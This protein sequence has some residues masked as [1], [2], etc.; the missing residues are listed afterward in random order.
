MRTVLHLAVVSF[1]ACLVACENDGKSN[2]DQDGDGI[3]D[4]F[5]CNDGDPDIG[6]TVSY[7]LDADKDGY[8][9]I[10]GQIDIG[11]C[12]PPEGFVLVGG[13]CND[14]DAD[15]HPDADEI[16][17]TDL[18]DYD[19]DGKAPSLDEDG[20]GFA[21]C[22]DCDD[23]DPDTNPTT[24]WY[25]DADKD[26]FGFADS[27]IAACWQP[28]GYVADSSDC[29][30]G[31][32]ERHETQKWYADVDGDQY[33]DVGDYEESCRPSD[34]RVEDA[35]DCDDS[36]PTI[37]PK[38]NWYADTDDDGYGDLMAPVVSCRQPARTSAESTDC[39]DTSA[40]I[41]P[42][43]PELCDGKDNDCDT[44]I[45]DGAP[46]ATLYGDADG[47]HYGVEAY[48]VES[49]GDVPGFAKSKGDC[50]DDDAA[51]HPGVVD[52]FCDG[53]DPGCNGEMGAVSFDPDGAAPAKSLTAAFAAGKADDPVEWA[54]EDGTLAICEGTYFVAITA[55]A[56]GL[57]IESFRGPVVLDGAG[58]GPVFDIGPDAYIY[59]E[60]GFV[61]TRGAGKTISESTYGGA[62]VIAAN[63]AAY[64]Q[65]T[66]FEA[67]AAS[68][69]GAI[70]LG[71]E[72]ELSGGAV[73]RNTSTDAQILLTGSDAFLETFQTNFGTDTLS[74]ADIKVE[75][76]VYSHSG[77][78]TVACGSG[79]G[80]E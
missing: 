5:D 56:V 22:I 77:S 20:D 48:T 55:D 71:G 68:H 4:D 73:E 47:D 74:P 1:V 24:L 25:K 40:A 41:A 50:D 32:D 14:L 59:A 15:F 70:Y 53:V 6:A 3:T 60:D 28:E 57:D 62:M 9:A 46:T 34:G 66:S 31:D 64:F 76:S 69:G 38:T 39:D 63:G 10:D 17:C 11:D 12:Q 72:L 19:C 2:I 44:V 43:K 29:D 42:G 67:N 45:D 61:A 52:L 75:A 49:C 35:S 51:V 13:D 21:A 7:F 18:N 8:G 26:G 30:D 36:N 33:G 23:A 37:N 16:D 79:L 58:K 27:T 54:A 80:C 78:W 65:N